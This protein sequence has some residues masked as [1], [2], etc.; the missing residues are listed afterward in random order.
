ME[1]STLFYY[2]FHIVSKLKEYGVILKMVKNITSL[3]LLSITRAG[4]LCS[5]TILMAQELKIFK[6]SDFDLKGSVK[7]CLVV[8]NY[9]KEEFDFNQDG[10]LTKSIT[11]YNEAD[12][13]LTLYKYNFGNLEEKRVE[14]YREGIFDPA[15]SF[16][17]FYT[18][19]STVSKKITERII[20]YNKEFLGQ[21]EYRY[22]SIGRLSRIKHV[23]KGGIDETGI[24]YM[25]FK[26]ETTVNYILNDV[27]IKSVRTAKKK[28]KT[29]EDQKVVLTKEYLKGEPDKA[30][31][32]IFD[33]SDK[34]ISE[35]KFKP[36]EQ[37]KGFAPYEFISHSYNEFGMLAETKI[38]GPKA[39]ET[40][41]Y[42]YQYDGEYG[43][44]VK[45]IVTPDNTY[46]SRRIMYY[47]TTEKKD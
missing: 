30:L 14:I 44:W 43:N 15:T 47:A 6:V 25:Q 22:D 34:L 26:G 42:I 19:D 10:L 29:G 13:D 40:K 33:S 45:Q 3:L 11:R 31:E 8:T 7:T 1:I 21:N 2:L 32:Q 5:S 27:M 28:N 9:G 46:T 12:Y 38:K 16:A 18:L 37:N 24:S 23:D 17:N 35:I 39:E 20:S 36:N 4:F 41:K